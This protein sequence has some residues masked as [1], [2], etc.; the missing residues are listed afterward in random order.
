MDQPCAT[1]AASPETL[2]RQ[3][4]SG[5]PASFEELVRRFQSPLLAFLWRRRGSRADAEDL[6]QETFLRVH[7]TLSRY[8]GRRPFATWLFTIAHR[9]AINHHASR[10]TQPLRL[11]DAG[12]APLAAGDPPPDERAA[13][14]EAADQLWGVARGLLSADQFTALWLRVVEEMNPSQIARVLGRSAVAVRVELHR[15]RRRL[16]QHLSDQSVKPNPEV[17]HDPAPEPSRI[18]ATRG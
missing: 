12:A 1:I 17:E 4:Q 13:A 5:C 10:A 7:R 16:Q 14:A 15:A 8:D 18:A 11:V 3:A 9:L 2:A 6:V